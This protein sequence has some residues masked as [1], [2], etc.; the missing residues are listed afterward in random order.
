MDLIRFGRGIR[1]LRLR[2]RWRQVDL[3]AAARVSQSVVARIELGLGGR[4]TVEILARVAA[5]LGARIDVRLNWQGEG[6]DRLLDQ[7]HAELVEIVAGLLRASGWD[8]RTEVTFAIRGERGSIDLLAWHRAT[9]VVLVVEVK[10]V[11]P[12]QQAALMGLDRKARLGLDI[13]ASMDWQAVSVGRLLAI[14]ASRTARRRVEAHRS[15]Y[16]AALPDRFVA[17]RR[18]IR[19]PSPHRSQELRGLIFVSGSPRLTTRHR[20]PAARRAR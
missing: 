1:A 12:D 14:G 10:S 2:R 8:I 19:S 11:V 6:L 7:H 16:E 3:A 20:Q 17:V 15:T 18:F 9:G 5:S 4:M 13:A